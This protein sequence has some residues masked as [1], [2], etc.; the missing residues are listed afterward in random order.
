MQEDMAQLRNLVQTQSRFDIPVESPL[1]LSIEKV[2]IDRPLK[3]PALDQFDGS[4]DPS[5]F[6]NTFDR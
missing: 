2:N 6:L 3:N 5:G 4:T 1:S